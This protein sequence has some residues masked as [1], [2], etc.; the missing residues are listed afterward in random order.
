MLN[1]RDR[2]KTV[3]FQ[4]EN[5]NNHS[6]FLIKASSKLFLLHFFSLFLG[7]LLNF[8][9]T[10]STDLNTYGT[11]IYI[12]TFLSLLSVISLLGVDTLIVKLSGRLYAGNKLQEI[13]GLALFALLVVLLTS[14]IMAFFSTVISNS[15]ENIKNSLS[16][17]WSL[18]A[19]LAI[20][21]LTVTTL[22]QAFLQG[23]KSVI[24][25]Q[26]GEKIIKPL[27]IIVAVIIL[28]ASK[29]NISLNELVWIN[30]AATIIA[31]GITLF[32][33]QK[34]VLFKITAAKP[35]YEFSNWSNLALSF[36]VI[37]VL[38]ILNSRIDII[39][40]GAI[41]GNDEVG[42]YN[43]V[44]KLS[45]TISF[46]LVLN[47]FVLAPLISEL[48]SKSN[49]NQLQQLVTQSARLI[50]ITGL[51]ILLLL[52][53]FRKS[54][55]AFFGADFLEGQ[56]ALIILCA[57]Q[58]INILFGSVGQLLIMSGNQ[59]LAILSL[60]ISTFIHIVL[61]IILTPKYGYTGT[62]IATAFSLVLW[63]ILMYYFVKKKLKICT[64]AFG[65]V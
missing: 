1:I 15:L 31:L 32:Y 18:L 7:F 9:L 35:T 43:I 59:K 25:S 6:V 5:E 4:K 50:L 63:N 58:L 49:S 39:L 27:F 3:F 23:L 46:A 22:S 51:P 47:N 48:Y 53:L 28:F 65:I 36:F 34:K 14:I 30:I 26:V 62:A 55:L 24:Q 8:I 56:A 40:L 37:S 52:I 61:N 64:T 10:R 16:I 54:I 38:Y 45:E 19:L 17:H 42:I 20:L 11:Y 21:L 33:L 29:K 57:G 2:I 44:S 12:F 60:A 41:R 13:K